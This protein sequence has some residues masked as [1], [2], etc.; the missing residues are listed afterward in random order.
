MADR[1]AAAKKAAKMKKLG[2]ASRRA[3]E[4]KRR[5]AV[6]PGGGPAGTDVGTADHQL[7]SGPDLAM[8]T[9]SEVP[10]FRLVRSGMRTSPHVFI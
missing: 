4:I 7:K 9:D 3:A 8:T 5:K 10:L 2:A 6:A 1:S